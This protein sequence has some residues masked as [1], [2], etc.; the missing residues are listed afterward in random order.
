MTQKEI[1]KLDG[2][3]RAGW[4]YYVAGY[5]QDQIANEFGISRQ[6]AQRMVS[7]AMT[8]KL[9]KVRLDHPISSC[10]DLNAKLIKKYNLKE[11]EIIPS[12]EDG[13]NVTGLGE[14]GASMMEKYLLQE[15]KLIIAVGTGR[16]L[17]MIA[18]ELSPINS[19]QHSIISLVGNMTNDGSASAHEVVS[20]ISD[21]VNATY[22]PMP[23]PVIAN[24]SKEK[25][26]LHSLQSTSSILSL[27]KHVD[28]T[29]VGIGQFDQNA[30]LYKDS[31]INKEELQG[32]LEA[33]AVGEITGWAYNNKGEIIQGHSNDKVTSIPLVKNSKKVVIA[34]AAG[35]NKQEAI[36]A[37]LEG[38]LINGLIT[39]ERMAE[40]L[41]Q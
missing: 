27:A 8:E 30:P 41:L 38:K 1:D 11:C 17:K 40:F 25:E 10:M 2:A 28:V 21:K 9:I 29:F 31:F 23:L 33:K 12:V 3:A 18:N 16:V 34:I 24:S 7:L 19:S 14:A 36:K 26:L 5:T 6:S 20:K 32:L 22:F 39:N 4:L 13:N 35:D 15:K 37:A